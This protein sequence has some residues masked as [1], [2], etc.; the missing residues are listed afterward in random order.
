MAGPGQK[1]ANPSSKVS[2][3]NPHDIVTTDWFYLKRDK[4][5]VDYGKEAEQRRCCVL[6][7]EVNQAY[8]KK[9]KKKRKKKLGEAAGLMSST[10]ENSRRERSYTPNNEH[11][12]F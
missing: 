6:M 3:K 4:V 5:V 10:H 7:V 2:K 12:T 1:L 9:Q 8:L 11:V